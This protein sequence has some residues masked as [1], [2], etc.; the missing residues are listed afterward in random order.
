MGPH[1]GKLVNMHTLN[2][3]S[4]R[5]DCGGGCCWCLICAV[6][7]VHCV[8]QGMT[9]VLKELRPWVHIWGSW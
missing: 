9:S 8:G 2:L 5:C 3:A 6:V 7:C 1:L 4:T